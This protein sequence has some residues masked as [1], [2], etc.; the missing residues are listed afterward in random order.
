MGQCL[1]IGFSFGCVG[2]T[3][4][5]EG[6]S[7]DS[8]ISWKQ[9]C[10]DDDIEG[11]VL[12]GTNTFAAGADNVQTLTATGALTTVTTRSGQRKRK[13]KWQYKRGRFRCVKQKTKKRDKRGSKFLKYN[14]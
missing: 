13:C 1:G 6:C 2:Y 11:A 10:T 9:A 14:F 3:L 5:T 8:D 4:K 12:R 7:V